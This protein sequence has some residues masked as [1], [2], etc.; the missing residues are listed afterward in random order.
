MGEG[1]QFA[2]LAAIVGKK[3]CARYANRRVTITAVGWHEGQRFVMGELADGSIA[4]GEPGD[5][6]IPKKRTR[7]LALPEPRS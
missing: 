3:L 2:A 1:L 6:T 7:R 5:F 4:L